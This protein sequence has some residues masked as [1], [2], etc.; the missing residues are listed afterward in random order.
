MPIKD[1]VGSRFGRL[2]VVSFARRDKAK[3]ETY[4]LCRCDCGV[5]KIVTNNALMHGTTTSC[6]CFHKEQL[7]T[8][9]RKHGLCEGRRPAVIRTAWGNAKARCY[10][11]NN[12]RYKSYGGRGIVMC[13]GWRNDA[14]AFSRDIGPRPEGGTID[15]IDV[16]GHYSC[17]KCEECQQNG[18]PMNV[19]WAS[20][21]EQV[22]NKTSS[23]KVTAFG[24]TKTV[25]QWAES[26]GMRQILLW[27]R[28]KVHGWSP[29]KAISE[30][31]RNKHVLPESNR[32]LVVHRAMVYRCC[33]PKSKAYPRYGGRGI[34]VCKRWRDDKHAFVSDM[35]PKPTPKHSIDRIDN[36]KG[37]WCGKTECPECGPLG[38]VGNCRWATSKEQV[39]NRSIKSVAGSST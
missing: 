35:G 7:A 12:Y 17:G 10:N 22:N 5:E 9:N 23:V 1:K 2:V 29:E 37:Y 24:E 11:K 36:D 6:G 32:M 20:K 16:N 14:S 39:R 31:L 8:R 4:W 13:L 19:R 15:R 3:R 27:T 28:I 38:R 25:A 34:T 30:P 21:S 18:W 26:V 33:C